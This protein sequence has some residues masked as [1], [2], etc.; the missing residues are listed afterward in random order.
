V[1]LTLAI[2]YR[3]G[4]L[5]VFGYHA[6]NL[7]I[8]ILVGLVLFGIVR[9]TLSGGR[10]RDIFGGAALV[11]SFLIALL[12]LVHPIQ[13]E[14]VTYIIQRTESLMGLFY[15]LTLYCAIRAAGSGRR[16][17]WYVLS[18]VSCG[19]GMA[20]KEV[21]VTAPVMVLF[22]DRTFLAGSFRQ[23]VRRRW[24]FYLFLSSTWLVLI[25]LMLPGPRAGST[26]F[27]LGV[28]ALSYAANQCEVLFHYLRLSFWPDRLCLDYS[29][30]VNSDWA[31][32]GPYIAAAAAVIAVTI[33]GFIHNRSWSFAGV[34][35][36]VILSPTSSF[37]PVAD[38]V[39]EHR[40]YLPLAGLTAV[41]VLF[42]YIVLNKISGRLAMANRLFGFGFS[43]L[44]ILAVLLTART[45]ARNR[46]YRTAVSIWH[47]PQPRL[48]NRS[49]NL[50]KGR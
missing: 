14:S 7:L 21:M 29:K 25:F 24:P 41:V 45:L 20:T 12:W 9:R 35:F 17:I 1:S 40:M 15:L 5:N 11:L 2:N 48:P 10:L 46:D 50:A 4:G 8:H 18:V 33:W 32:L 44:L 27:S 47:R 16:V 42:G 38:L 26:G 43:I 19:F 34:W 49:F 3:L 30:A 23:A 39:F 36:F 6:L 28:S 22:Y 13:T 37:I 31:K